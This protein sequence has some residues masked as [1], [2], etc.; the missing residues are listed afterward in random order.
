MKQACINKIWIHQIWNYNG[1]TVNATAHPKWQ[2]II[3]LMYV[4]LV[5]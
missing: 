1:K 3:S 5:E 2:K 4:N